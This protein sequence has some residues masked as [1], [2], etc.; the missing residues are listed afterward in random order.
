MMKAEKLEAKACLRAL[1]R[2]RK[3]AAQL[4]DAERAVKANGRRVY[5]RHGYFGGIDERLLESLAVR[6]LA[7]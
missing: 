3:L 7:A 4:A 6:D 1:D 2:K 5:D